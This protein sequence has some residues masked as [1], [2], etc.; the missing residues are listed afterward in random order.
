[1][2]P[3]L[4]LN[5]ST[6]CSGELLLMAHIKYIDNYEITNYIAILRTIVKIKDVLKIIKRFHDFASKM[7]DICLENDYN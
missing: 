1:M 6:L 3:S 5:Y 7:I 4:C 2:F